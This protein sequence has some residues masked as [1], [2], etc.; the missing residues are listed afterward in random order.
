M[1]TKLGIWNVK[2]GIS[3]KKGVLAVC[4]SIKVLS[5]DRALVLRSISEFNMGR[6]FCP[7][8]I[9][10]WSSYSTLEIEIWLRFGLLLIW[11]RCQLSGWFFW[12]VSRA[13]VMELP[14]F[15]EKIRC[16][17][18]TITGVFMNLRCASWELSLLLPRGSLY[19]KLGFD[20]YK[21]RQNQ[22]GYHHQKA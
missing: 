19:P 14:D 20:K 12:K 10:N 1:M 4:W 6:P 21:S 11:R 2:S 8:S 7:R 15:K 16:C 18:T 22:A 5:L 17:M 3:A 9:I 13:L